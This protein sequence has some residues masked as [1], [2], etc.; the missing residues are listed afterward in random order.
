MV[1]CIQPGLI[2][3]QNQRLY[4]M[5]IVI[6]QT[7]FVLLVHFYN[8]LNITSE[9]LMVPTSTTTKHDELLPHILLLHHSANRQE[10]SKSLFLLLTML[11]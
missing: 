11:K 3:S 7:F 8:T 4:G 1:H 6:I 9:F 10:M 5:N 2:C